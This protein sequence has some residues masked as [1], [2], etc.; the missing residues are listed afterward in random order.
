MPKRRP[1][2]KHRERRL[3][4]ETVEDRRL[5]ALL[6]NTSNISADDGKVQILVDEYGSF[7][8]SVRIIDPNDQPR[9][10]IFS[11]ANYNPI[12]N[13]PVLDSGP[14]NTVNESGV[15]IQITNAINPPLPVNPN[16]LSTGL[17]GETLFPAGGVGSI[18]AQNGVMPTPGNTGRVTSTF[19]YPPP[20]TTN[21]AN[22]FLDFELTQT[23]QDLEDDNGDPIGTVLTQEYEIRRHP[24]AP[25]T[26]VTFVLSRYMNA[27]LHFPG[28]PLDD[29]GNMLLGSDAVDPTAQTFV[30]FTTDDIF[31]ANLADN[32]VAIDSSGGVDLRPGRR[33]EINQYDLIAAPG[34]G[35]SALV[36]RMI[37][38][39]PLDEV[40]GPGGVFDVSA[41]NAKSFTLRAND[42]ARYITR[43]YFASAA[44]QDV[45]QDPSANIQGMVFE[46]LNGDGTKQ[47]SE[48]VLVG[49]TVEL[50]QGGN[51]VG[52]DTSDSAGRYSIGIMPGNTYTVRHQVPLDFTSTTPQAGQ[53][54]PNYNTS[55]AF[56]TVQGTPPADIDFGYQDTVNAVITGTKWEDVNRNG[57]IDGNDRKLPGWTIRVTPC[58]VPQGRAICTATTDVNGVYRLRVPANMGPYT[59]SETNQPNPN[60]DL[61]T[62]WEPVMPASGMYTGQGFVVG[63]NPPLDFLNRPAPGTV[64][65][66]KFEDDNADGIPDGV[67]SVSFRIYSDLNNNGAFDAG[68]PFDMTSLVDGSYRIEDL[69]PNQ[70]HRILEEIPFEWEQTFPS[71]NNPYF[72]GV[73]PGEDVVG[74]DFGNRLKSGSISGLK[75]LDANG[76]GAYDATTEPGLPNFYIY[77]DLDEDGR[78]G[79]MEPAAITGRGGRYEIP[80]LRP[81]NYIVREVLEPGW[82]QTVPGNNELRVTVG[83][84]AA[85]NNVNFG[86]M[87]GYDHGDAPAP[88]PTL[89]A[90]NGPVHAIVGPLH[91]GAYIDGEADGFQGQDPDNPNATDDNTGTPDDEDGVVFPEPFAPGFTSQIEVTVETGNLAPG[92]LQAWI[93]FNGDGDWSDP[94]EQIFT[95]RYLGAGTY[96]LDVSVPA[97]AVPGLTYARFRYANAMN[98][99]FVGPATTGEVEDYQVRI[100]GPDVLAEDD[101]ATVEMNSMDNAI[102][103]LLNDTPSFRLNAMTGAPEAALPLE[104]FSINTSGIQGTV[105]IDDNATGN[106]PTDDVLRYT[107]APGFLGTE[108]FTYSVVDDAGQTDTASVTVTVTFPDGLFVVDDSYNVALNSAANT[109]GVLTNDLVGDG[110]TI[111][112]STFSQ[113]AN[114]FVAPGPNDTLLY[115]PATNFQGTDQF[116][117]VA[118]S[119]AGETAAGTVTVHVGDTSLDNDLVRIRLEFADSAGNV[120][121]DNMIPVGEEFQVR[122][123]VDD[124]RSGAND[125]GV[126]SA[127]LDLLYDSF[128]VSLN[129][130]NNVFNGDIVY[131]PAFTAAQNAHGEIPGVIDE[132]GAVQDSQTPSGPNELLLFTATFT[133]NQIGTAEFFADPAD[134]LPDHETSIYGMSAPVPF[135]QIDFDSEF[136]TIAPANKLVGFRLEATDLAGNALANNEIV[137]G[138]QFKIRALVDDLRSIADVPAAMQGVYSAYMDLVFNNALVTPATSVITPSGLDLVFSSNYEAGRNAI[139]AS[140]MIDEIGALQATSTPL[141]ANELLLYEITFNADSA[142]LATF[143]TNPADLQPQHEVSL[144]NP[145]APV[146]PFDIDFG[147]TTVNVLPSG[148]RVEFSFS[149]TDLNHAALPNNAVAPGSP[150]L[151]Q[152]WVEDLRALPASSLGVFSAYTDFRFDPSLVTPVASGTNPTGIDIR[153][154]GNYP[155]GRNAVPLPGLLAEEGALREGGP[156]GAGRQVLFE[157]AFTGNAGNSGTGIFTTDPAD[158]LPLHEVTTHIPVTSIPSADIR[159]KSASLLV[160]VSPVPFQNPLNRMDVNAD[161]EVSP[162]DALLAINDLNA[163]GSRDLS[164]GEGEAGVSKFIDVNG[165]NRSTPND[166]IIIINWLNSKANGG[167]GEGAADL[168]LLPEA[169]SVEGEAADATDSAANV[170]A[171][172]IAA[173]ELALPLQAANQRTVARSAK[174][175]DGGEDAQ[176]DL[177]TLLAADVMATWK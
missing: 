88:Y 33:W 154:S 30:L 68:E 118:A 29:D 73:D 72:F 169:E 163:H 166:P 146:S 99:S 5:L 94:N 54:N 161:G 62:I 75:F 159:Y 157:V 96:S 83:A 156:L 153:F 130:A 110:E 122:A 147:S 160:G 131:G 126:F 103:V 9:S 89:L 65:G 168:V 97:N 101:A 141:G 151:A 12:P 13:S 84:A 138:N 117:Y 135:Q 46:D 174:S 128:F 78:L 87:S 85:T 123:Y 134:V 39:D 102:D 19:S 145:P 61:T 149:F 109:L 16:F 41:A 17:L 15:M 100:Y 38:A 64:S 55:A 45:I 81:G 76:N 111:A 155:S 114:G 8:S 150:F 175:F 52:S 98:L 91:L 80:D 144:F 31:N 22:P 162:F 158:I 127:Y 142:G 119:S 25:V 57:V 28:A 129:P 173:D 136:L 172:T 3:L 139:S 165:D 92:F 67:P 137:A 82:I 24:L 148:G 20:G 113:P 106:D 108:T 132:I 58:P 40:T 36:Q 49:E 60:N 124:L 26:D 21:P 32:L 95:N 2:S 140:G 4:F 48:P 120:L 35:S 66:N 53:M 79:F 71:A 167:S 77:V 121:Q 143:S 171:V 14:Q 7:G 37:A 170:T 6:T 23:L 125:R 34:T 18:G 42:V 105:T 90:D 51:V 70:E 59:V 1:N 11:F 27:D 152:M 50:L 44:P 43:T 112:V 116:Q 63:A 10:N 86:N 176:E 107:P 47:T 164:G 69:A 93:D 133:A 115:T 177:L 74:I 56:T 104:I